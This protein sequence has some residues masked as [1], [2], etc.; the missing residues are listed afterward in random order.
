MSQRYRAQ[1]IRQKPVKGGREPLPSCVT[2]EIWK[3]VDRNARKFN[4]SRSFV[5]AVAL[6]D[7]FGIE[8]DTYKVS[9]DKRTLNWEKPLRLVASK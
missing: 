5:I 3:E 1:T 6:A 7:Q 4:V 8:I 9:F 2:R